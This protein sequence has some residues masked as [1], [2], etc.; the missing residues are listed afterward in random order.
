MKNRIISTYI[1][2]LK[3]RIDRKQ[4]I[5]K[6]FSGRKNFRILM[7]EAHEHKVGS[8]GLWNTIQYILQY[9]VN[10]QDEFI[11]LCEDDHQFTLE[12]SMEMLYKA[13]AEAKEKDADMLAGGISGFTNAVKVSDHLYWVEKFSGSQFTLIF[14]KFYQKI[15]DADFRAGDASDYKLCSLTENKFFIYPFLSIQKDFGY[16]DATPKNNKPGLIKELFDQSETKIQLLRQVSEFY[17]NKRI[18]HS[19]NNTNSFRNITIPTYVINLPQRKD[20][21][22]HIEAQFKS[23]DEFDV[24][25]VDACRNEIGAVGLWASIRK[26]IQ[27]AIKNDDDVI[28]I[29]E[30]DHQFTLDYSWDFLLENIILAHEYS[31]DLLSCGSAILSSVCLIA[32]NLFWMNEYYSTQ[33]IV[34]YRKF[35]QKILDEPFDN[36]VVADGLLSEMTPNKMLLYPYISIQKDFGYSDCTSLNNRVR[37]LIDNYFS[38]STA[39]LSTINRMYSKYQPPFEH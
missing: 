10:R 11:I 29:C 2:N 37:R 12:Y 27:M 20:R 16:S 24:R 35:F 7:V 39:R 31:A 34:V 33:F 4:H 15:L 28:I 19:P 26:I 3:T 5:V 25:I 36:T 23:K 8:I 22:N 38:E 30:D 14:K 17:M 18:N 21:R 9:L 13:I 1:I 32:K 6:E